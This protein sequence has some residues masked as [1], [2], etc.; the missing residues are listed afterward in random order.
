MGLH[1]GGAYEVGMGWEEGRDAK[2]CCRQVTI[3]SVPRSHFRVV[4]FRAQMSVRRLWGR[5]F[6]PLPDFDTGILYLPCF[7][8]VG[9]YSYD[10]HIYRQ[11]SKPGGR[12]LLLLS[13]NNS[14]SRLSDASLREADIAMVSRVD[15]ISLLEDYFPS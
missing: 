13:V 15:R 3:T 11:L 7:D 1:S 12:Y 10:Q 6:N 8:V 5:I 2:A 14:L 9:L 4:A